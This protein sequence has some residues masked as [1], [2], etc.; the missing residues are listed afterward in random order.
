MIAG[1][2]VQRSITTYIPYPVREEV[3]PIPRTVFNAFHP[4]DKLAARALEQ[5]GKV[6]I[7]D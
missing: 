4:Y 7:V 3:L 6:R 2:C 1:D 5:V